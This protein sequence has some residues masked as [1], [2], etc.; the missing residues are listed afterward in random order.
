[1]GVGVGAGAAYAPAGETK[2]PPMNAPASSDLCSAPRTREPKGEGKGKGKGEDS[3][4]DSGE[5][6]II[7][8]HLDG[9][10]AYPGKLCEDGGDGWKNIALASVTPRREHV[11][12]SQVLHVGN[13]FI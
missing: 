11:T 6:G 3:G 7:R 8:D 4:E 12:V 5:T 13:G 10:D 1:V 2:M 9:L